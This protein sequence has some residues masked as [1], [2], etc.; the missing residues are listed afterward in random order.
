MVPR[1]PPEIR[2]E[3][4]NL[5]LQAYSR[6]DISQILGISAGTVSEVVKTY[7][8][9]NPGF[10]LLRELVVAI[11]R[12]G[13]NTREY[14]SAIRLRRLL[15]N[16]NLSEE[17]VDSLIR[18]ATNHCFKQE[19]DMQSFIENVTSAADLS[20]ELEIALVELSNHIRN[21]KKEL[22]LIN[23]R[24]LRKKDKL[25][26]VSK[27]LIMINNR[28]Q[29]FR[30]RLPTVEK[31]EWLIDNLTRQRDAALKAVDLLL[32]LRF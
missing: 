13:S 11:K 3:I 7:G 25:S 8:Q 27:E 14:A 10:E 15:N 26:K 21:L 20:A 22:G 32:G 31:A 24:L 16:N 9:R 19:V 5:W 30:K 1:V 6:D 18:N 29:E 12:E 28:L 4:L 17:E 23:K 2:Q